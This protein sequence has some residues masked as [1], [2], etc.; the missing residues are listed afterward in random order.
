MPRGS[1][2]G[3]LHCWWFRN[4]TTQLRLVAYPN[5]YRVWYIPAGCLGFQP[6]T[7]LYGMLTSSWN[8]SRIPRCIDRCRWWVGHTLKGLVSWAPPTWQAGKWTVNEDVFPIKM[9]DFP[10]CHVS[11][12]EGRSRFCPRNS[13]RKKGMEFYLRIASCEL[14]GRRIILEYNSCLKS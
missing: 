10:T 7:V 8:F 1:M 13:Q 12:Q 14:S 2:Y 11:F 5:I 9:V 3:I 6:S 4:P